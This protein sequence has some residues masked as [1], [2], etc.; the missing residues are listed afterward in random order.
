MNKIIIGLLVMG[1]LCSGVITAE[2][3]GIKFKDYTDPYNRYSIKYPSK[4]SIQS[5]PVHTEGNYL[6]EV[7]F[8]VGNNKGTTLLVTEMK[9]DPTLSLREFA[10]IGQNDMLLTVKR[11]ITPVTCI[12]ETNCM[13]FYAFNS[14]GLDELGQM[15][16][17]HLGKD[18]KVFMVTA[19]FT[20]GDQIN[21]DQFL[22][23]ENSL[24]L[25]QDASITTS[26]NYATITKG[27]N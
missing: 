2:A 13:Y 9:K 3:K 19:T 1:V 8:I 21:S 27:G 16:T 22:E 18:N 5:E 17:L 6:Y 20:A 14:Y 24:S 4:W 23:M 11:V 7:P 26:N 10:S 12:S 25:L 15:V